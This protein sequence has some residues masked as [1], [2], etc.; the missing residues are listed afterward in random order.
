MP[1]VADLE[2]AYRQKSTDEGRCSVCETKYLIIW[3]NATNGLTWPAILY[4]ARIVKA[5]SS[6]RVQ[7]PMHSYNAWTNTSYGAHTTGALGLGKLWVDIRDVGN[8]TKLNVVPGTPLDGFGYGPNQFKIYGDGASNWKPARAA[9]TRELPDLNRNSLYVEKTTKVSQ[10]DYVFL[11]MISGVADSE[12]V[13]GRTWINETD[14]YGITLGADNYRVHKTQALAVHGS[15][16]TT[17][18]GEVTSLALTAR[19][20]GILATWTDPV[21]SDL[22]KILV[23]RRTSAIT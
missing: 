8:F 21:D 15:P 23:Y 7:I 6:W 22:D 16:D 13:T 2:P 4:Y 10:E 18:P 12:P 19:D 5:D 1:V 3:P 20:R 11:L 14:W 17:P 9:K